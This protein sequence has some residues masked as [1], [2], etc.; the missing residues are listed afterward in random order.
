MEELLKRIGKVEH[1][2]P[3]CIVCAF[4]K[5]IRKYPGNTPDTIKVDFM[6][7]VMEMMANAEKTTALPVIIRDI[8]K[9]RIEMFGFTDD[10]TEI[11]K[12]FNAILLD[13][14][15][16]F[17]R[18]IAE[19]ED[20]L[21]LAMQLALVG[22]YIDFGVIDQ[23]DEDFLNQLIREAERKTFE[24]ETYTRLKEDLSAGGNLVF[25]TDNCGE[26]VMDRLLIEQIKE[27]YPA[28]SVSVVVRGMPTM[29]DATMEDAVQVGLTS[30]S[31]VDRV[32]GNGNDIMG[33]WLP[34]LSEEAG[35]LLSR[36]DLIIAKGQANFETL[37][38]CG[39]NIYYLFL[40]KCDLFAGMF[41]V[42]RLSGM[43]I[44]DLD[45]RNNQEE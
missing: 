26:I 11:K 21:K 30:M 4:N 20:P 2:R 10:Y 19:A 43:L 18:R 12:H 25:L 29:N 15:D 24:E 40:C 31:Q 39:L 16:S 34:E 17:R 5:Y 13:R 28:L 6:Q 7:R 9:L 37:R 41:H 33:T 44:N 27:M 36:A 3:D 38:R 8:D 42:P 14:I 1:L 22:N 45:P 32:V 23:V 35:I